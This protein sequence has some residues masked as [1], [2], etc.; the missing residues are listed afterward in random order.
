MVRTRKYH[1]EWDNSDP[2]EYAYC[3]LTN[4]WRLTKKVQ[5]SQ[6]I[7]PSVPQNT[8]WLTRDSQYSK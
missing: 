1:P 2:K 6:D 3:V 8:R 5:I 7:I 4:K